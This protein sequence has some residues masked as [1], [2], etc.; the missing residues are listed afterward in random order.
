[1]TCGG[2]GVLLFISGRGTVKLD[3]N[4]RLVL[5]ADTHAMYTAVT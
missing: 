5:T 4:E 3:V 2:G 1:M